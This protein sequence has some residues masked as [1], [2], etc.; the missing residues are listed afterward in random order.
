VRIERAI[1]IRG[2]RGAAFL[3]IINLTNRKNTVSMV[4][5]G[6]LRSREPVR[7]LPVL[8]FLGITIWG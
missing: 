5:D 4:W 1:T 6:D 2:R 3:E 8:P 7:G